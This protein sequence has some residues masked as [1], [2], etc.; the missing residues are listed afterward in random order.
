MKKIAICDDEIEFQKQMSGYLKQLEPLF[1][2]D[3]YDSGEA[4]LDSEIS[5]DIIFLDIDMKGMSGIDT[6]RMLRL[7]DKKVKIIYITAYDDFQNYA[8]SVHAF[9]YLVKPVEKNQILDI[10]NEAFTYTE[11]EKNG[12]KIRLL[13][14]SGYEEL[15]IRDIY[16]FEYENRKIKAVTSCGIFHLSGTIGALG[17][18]MQA[19]GF[20]IP[21]K[22]FVVNLSHIKNIKGYDLYLTNG[23][24]VPL[25]QKKSSQFREHLARWLALQI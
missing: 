15:L 6:A 24:I 1:L 19:F 22:S 16:Y 25:S 17:E 13:T 9:G 4:L 14:E 23:S 18:K 3:C 7:R 8:F 12:P 10:L 5:Y 11:E 2:A 20:E 21:H